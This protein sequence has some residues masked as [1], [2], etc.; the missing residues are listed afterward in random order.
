MKHVKRSRGESSKSTNSGDDSNRQRGR[1]RI[2]TRDETATE[3]RR[4]QIRLAQR[5]YRERKESTIFA[6]H[7]RVAKL[8]GIIIDMNLN[9]SDFESKARQSG[10]LDIGL[11]NEL[12]QTVNVMT[13]LASKG[14]NESPG[15]EDGERRVSPTE[16]VL[17]AREEPNAYRKPTGSDAVPPP[18][19]VWGYEVSHDVPMTYDGA[20]IPREGHQP[21][22]LS[23]TDWTTTEL[24]QDLPTETSTHAAPE[25]DWPSLDAW[26]SQDT[27]NSQHA[28]NK[29][30]GSGDLQTDATVPQSWQHSTY[31]SQQYNIDM[32]EIP[33]PVKDAILSDL[34]VELSL[35]QTSSYT[36]KTFA[37]RIIRAAYES[38]HRLMTTPASNPAEIKRLCRLTYCFASHEGML[39]SVNSLLS[40][41]ANE[42]LELWSLPFLH[43]GNS[44]LHYPRDGIDAGMKPPEGWATPMAMGPYPNFDPA[45]PDANQFTVKE[46]PGFADVTGE[47]FDSN[48]VEQYLRTK[49]L[50]IN[51]TSSIVEIEEP[52]D[53]TLSGID[54]MH[55]LISPESSS[56]RDGSSA[57]NSPET[58]NS[59]GPND[60][61]QPRND[62][63]LAFTP[64]GALQATGAHVD[65][66]FNMFHFDNTKS[67]DSSFTFNMFPPFETA[68][69]PKPKR[70]FDVDLFLESEYCSSPLIN[71]LANLDDRH[72]STK[73][74]FGTDI[75]FPTEC[76]R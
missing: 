74:L 65:S 42:N 19:S 41:K 51:S 37:R 75:V 58:V 62:A 1:P 59:T 29:A 55:S 24:V 43:L 26:E 67:F 3:R 10:V 64:F 36:E 70:L 12:K 32:P 34:S 56:F 14:V 25:I 22:G 27:S 48:D 21:G 50:R 61:F 46:I 16:K 45:W 35:P 38:A 15:P 73:H 31:D 72:C 44:G 47:W 11:A 40:R 8:Q 23:D 54:D 76:G 30:S 63:N 7:R 39:S 60:P 5:A 18:V 28:P 71:A 9:F 53:A 33:M 49:G 17:S 6:L 57:P 13:N 4:M 52:A 2:D 68:V 66:T 69:K 20:F